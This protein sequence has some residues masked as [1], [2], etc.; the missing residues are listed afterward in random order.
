M[1]L[2]ICYAHEGD[3]FKYERIKSLAVESACHI[4]QVY[5]YP[6]YHDESH[7]KKNNW[8]SNKKG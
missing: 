8:Q 5:S 7:C 6:L 1:Y 4:T 2:Q 3:G